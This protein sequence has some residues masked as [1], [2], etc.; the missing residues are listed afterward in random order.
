MGQ[1]KVASLAPLSPGWPRSKKEHWSAGKRLVVPCGPSSHLLSPLR[2]WLTFYIPAYTAL[3]LLPLSYRR[4]YLLFSS[5]YIHAPHP[6]PKTITVWLTAPDFTPR[7]PCLR[8]HDSST[9]YHSTIPYTGTVYRAFSGLLLLMV[10][11]PHRRTPLRCSVPRLHRPSPFD[12]RSC[13]PSVV[14]R[15]LLHTGP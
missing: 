7:F 1:V 4:P 14:V 2:A 6:H 11:L 8:Y 5:P 10:L 13:Y 15:L 12:P 9:P 3:G